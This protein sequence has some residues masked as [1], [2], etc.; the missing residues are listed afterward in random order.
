MNRNEISESDEFIYRKSLQKI[1]ESYQVRQ[2]NKKDH[3]R[4]ETERIKAWESAKKKQSKNYRPG[5]K[6]L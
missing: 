1:K 3:K 5:R 2:G 4:N 6:C